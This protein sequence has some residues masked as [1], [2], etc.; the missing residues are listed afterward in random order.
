MAHYKGEFIWDCQEVDHGYSPG[1]IWYGLK[2]H[3]G[4]AHI[5]FSPY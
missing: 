1:L 2:P 5:E 4:L 3:T